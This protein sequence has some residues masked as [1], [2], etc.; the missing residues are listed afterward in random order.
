MTQ[1]T[2]VP[3]SWRDLGAL[4]AVEKTCFPKDAWPLW[5]LA[6][7]LTL[8]D[9]I[10]LKAVVNDHMAG[11]I[12]GDIRRNEGIGWITTLCVWP[13]HR[14]R[15]LAKALLEACEQQMDMPSVRLCVRRSNQAAIQL[16]LQNGYTQFGVWPA[17][18][19]DGEDAL[20][21]EKAI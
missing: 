12:A 9:I 1:W 5:D 7:V 8:P 19:H 10:R 13:E 3:A 18:Y 6:G 15:G 17:Y 4:R 21:L 16:Y 14:R 11:F 2:I 20:V